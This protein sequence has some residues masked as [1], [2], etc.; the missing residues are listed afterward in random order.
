MIEKV[1]VSENLAGCLD[2]PTRLSQSLSMSNTTQ[3]ISDGTEAEPEWVR[4]HST[5]AEMLYNLET[6]ESFTITHNESWGIM[7]KTITI[8]KGPFPDCQNYSETTFAEPYD[9]VLEGD[10]RRHPSAE[11]PQSVTI[12][13]D[14]EDEVVYRKP[15][16]GRFEE[17]EAITTDTLAVDYVPSVIT[18]A[19][20]DCGQTTKIPVNESDLPVMGNGMIKTDEGFITPCCH[21]D[22][23][24]TTLVKR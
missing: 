22:E 11:M 8:T 1:D 5:I 16:V 3:E 9:V 20:C 24:T 12:S 18:A 17:I 6:G 4:D 15:H 7:K 23:W 14:P 21:S 13:Y 10:Q 2:H 19:K